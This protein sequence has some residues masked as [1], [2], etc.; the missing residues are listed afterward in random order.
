[1]RVSRRRR[2][3]HLRRGR[4]RCQFNGKRANYSY[5]H[6]CACFAAVYFGQYCARGSPINIDTRYPLTRRRARASRD[7]RAR[8]YVHTKRVK[9]V[10]VVVVDDGAILLPCLRVRGRLVVHARARVV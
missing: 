4:F 6:A 5:V 7:I 8:A 1:M 2:R 3:L 9:V 10:V